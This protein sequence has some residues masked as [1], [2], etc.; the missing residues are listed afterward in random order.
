ME[1]VYFPVTLVDFYQTIRCCV[2]EGSSTYIQYNFAVEFSDLDNLKILF[3]Y[4]ITVM[5]TRCCFLILKYS[6]YYM[7]HV[8]H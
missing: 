4:E 6:G 1:A 3:F 8:Q 2:P 5:K 7:Y